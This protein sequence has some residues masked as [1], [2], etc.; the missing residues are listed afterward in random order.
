[1]QMIVQLG[2]PLTNATN[3]K[4]GLKISTVIKEPQAAVG[5]L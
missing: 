4:N 5:L 3:E 2:L 1:M